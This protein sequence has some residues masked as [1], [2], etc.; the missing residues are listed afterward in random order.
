MTLQAAAILD[1]KF[2]DFVQI[3]VLYFKMARK[4]NLAIEIHKIVGIHCESVSI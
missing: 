2:S 1:I 3:W 4:Q